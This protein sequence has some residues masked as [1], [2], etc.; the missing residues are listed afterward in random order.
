MSADW[1]AKPITQ[2]IKTVTPPAKV[3]QRDL[4]SDGPYPVVSQEADLISGYWD[5]PADVIELD[6]PAVVFG[7]HTGVIKYVDFPFVAG[8]DGP[9]ILRASDQVHPRYLYYF[10]LANPVKTLGYARHFK[11]VKELEIRFPRS[12]AEQKR[13]VAVLDEA[14]EAIERAEELDAS[15]RVEAASLVQSAIDQRINGHADTERPLEQDVRCIDYR[16]RT[17]PKTETGLPLITAKNV[18]MGYVKSEPKEFVDPGTYEAWMTRGI[19]KKGDVLFTTEAPLGNVAVLDRSDRVVFAQRVII[20][21]PDRTRLNP[22][23]LHYLLRSTAVQSRILAEGTGATATGI[24]ASRLKKIQIP[25]VSDTA[26]QEAMANALAGLELQIQ[27]L[28][29]VMDKRATQ[30]GRLRQSLL[31]AAFGD[32]LTSE[33]TEEMVPA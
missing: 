24:K 33:A 17:P 3:K 26:K 23:Y 21:Q 2:C 15:R 19:P 25:V 16:G 30:F 32:A 4:K 22:L 7:D 31:E 9:K 8:A 5:E 11:L 12:L 27:R 20:L 13:I 18:R 6:R 1:V 14:F 28:I 10:L 29:G